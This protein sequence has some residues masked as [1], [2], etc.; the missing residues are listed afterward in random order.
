MQNHQINQVAE[1]R[2]RVAFAGSFA[3][4]DLPDGATLGDIADRVRRLACQRHSL[5][6]AIE[7]RMAAPRTVLA[8]ADAR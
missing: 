6:A 5:P 8:S 7:V 4:L 1:P 2:L 3:A